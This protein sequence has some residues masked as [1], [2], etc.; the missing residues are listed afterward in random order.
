[1]INFIKDLFK[2]VIEIRYIKIRKPKKDELLIFSF[3]NNVNQSTLYDFSRKLERCL[4]EKH[5]YLILP[6]TIKTHYTNKNKIKVEKIG[7]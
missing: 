6:N 4:Q 5:N 3:K 2:K 1:M 7:K